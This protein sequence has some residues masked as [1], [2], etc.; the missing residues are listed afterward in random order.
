MK[1]QLDTDSK[2]IRIEE[3]VNL[4][5]LV[6]FI[7]NILPN[8]LWKEYSIEPHSTITWVNPITI[9]INPYPNPEPWP[10]PWIAYRDNTGIGTV[11]GV[12]NIQRE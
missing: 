11:S 7:Q 5:D 8:D 2:T 10:R 12:Y 4:A 9:P 3:K 6:A 1:I